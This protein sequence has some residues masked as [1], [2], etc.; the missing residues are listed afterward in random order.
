MDDGN[1]GFESICTGCISILK[2]DAVISGTE[3]LRNKLEEF[4]T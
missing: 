2:V 4:L 3:E 1:E